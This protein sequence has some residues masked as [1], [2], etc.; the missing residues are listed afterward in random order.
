MSKTSVPEGRQGRV[1]DRVVDTEGRR[2]SV[3]TTL[4]LSC[5]RHCGL[6]WT[7]LVP[8]RTPEGDPHRGHVGLI[9]VGVSLMLH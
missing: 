9:N 2:F 1:S 6:G 4:T 8:H 7:G 5:V 3:T